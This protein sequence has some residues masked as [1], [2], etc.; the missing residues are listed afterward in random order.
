MRGIVEFHLL[1]RIGTEK[2]KERKYLNQQEQDQEMMLDYES[3]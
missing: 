3:Q 1:I 2:Q